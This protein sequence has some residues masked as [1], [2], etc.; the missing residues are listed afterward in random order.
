MDLRRK[1]RQTKIVPK[2]PE[3]QLGGDQGGSKG[4]GREDVEWND[5]ERRITPSRPVHQPF[6]LPRS[7][8]TSKAFTAVT[9]WLQSTLSVY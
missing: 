6:R 5:E 3:A 9:G 7:K 1:D 8:R 2:A 4:K